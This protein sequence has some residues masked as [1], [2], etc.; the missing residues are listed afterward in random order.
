MSL[1]DYCKLVVL[2]VVLHKARQ[3][4]TQLDCLQCL[5]MLLSDVFGFGSACR[6]QGLSM[7][8]ILLACAETAAMGKTVCDRCWLSL[9][10]GP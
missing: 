4:S 2:L 10:R 3:T 1:P 5:Q 8:E 7:Q 6:L 9:P